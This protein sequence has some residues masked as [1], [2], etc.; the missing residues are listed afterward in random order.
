MMQ[1]VPIRVLLVDDHALV[2]A[3]LR[4]LLQAAGQ[5]EVVGEA[6]SSEE[7]CRVVAALTPDVIVLDISLPGVS[8][9][10]AIARLLRIMPTARIL[11]LS[12]H[13][14]E[15]FPAMALERGALGYLSKRGAPEELV[16]AVRKVAGGQ[17]YL[18][19]SVAQSMALSH[20][21]KNSNPL[22]LLSP[23]EVEIFVLLARGRSVNEIATA[24]NLSP[25]TVHAHRANVM[26]KLEVRGIAELVQLAVRSG[27]I[28]VHGDLS[29]VETPEL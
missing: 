19:N 16:T 12:M 26:R 11:M 21:R 24:I 7:A 27:A 25:K 15:P 10:E 28:D 3:G 8:G 13:D 4:G 22:S 9:I 20:L 1:E 14:S 17:R 2:R 6:A 18:G 23:R 29:A 5:I